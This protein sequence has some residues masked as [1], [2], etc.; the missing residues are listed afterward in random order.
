MQDKKDITPRN[1]Q[2]QRHGRWEEYHV[3]GTLYYR[4][5]YINNKIYGL[6]EYADFL[7]TIINKQYHAR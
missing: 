4:T 6:Y 2:G 1:K 5:N 7:K 3:N